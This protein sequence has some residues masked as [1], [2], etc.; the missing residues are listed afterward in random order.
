[1]YRIEILLFQF[2]EMNGIIHIFYIYLTINI[3]LGFK[4]WCNAYKQFNCCKHS[5]SSKFP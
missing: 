3:K 4:I 5:Y 1:M 2:Y